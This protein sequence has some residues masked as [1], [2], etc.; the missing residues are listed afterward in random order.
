MFSRTPILPEA[1]IV[2]PFRH[3]IEWLDPQLPRGD[4]DS[5]A[6]RIPEKHQLSSGR[7]IESLRTFVMADQNKESEKLVKKCGLIASGIE[8]QY[9]AGFNRIVVKYGED[10]FTFN[11]IGSVKKEDFGKL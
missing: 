5:M 1:E 3:R 11:L 9:E 10:D 8:I 7:S 6:E 4:A 2:Y